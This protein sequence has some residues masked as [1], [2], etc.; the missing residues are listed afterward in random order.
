[1]NSKNLLE[2]YNGLPG[3]GKGITVVGGLTLSAVAVITLIKRIKADAKLA[4]ERAAVVQSQTELNNSI[5]NNVTP[6]YPSSQY[7]SWAESIVTQITGCDFSSPGFGLSNS[8]YTIN[9]CFSKLKN[10]ADFLSLVTAY[11]VQTFPKCGSFLMGSFTGDLYSSIA[12]K[13][14]Q[15]ERDALNNTL[16]SNGIKYQV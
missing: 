12:Y 6:S 4:N 1:M 9:E 10:D 15:D 16:Q 13:L 2:V 11:D 8:Y 14:N 3:W 5:T 7:K